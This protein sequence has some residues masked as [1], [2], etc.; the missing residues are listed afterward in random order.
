ME[1]K[2]LGIAI[3]VVAV[4]LCG[5]PGLASLCVGAI[6]AFGGPFLGEPRSDLLFSLS[7]LCAGL[8]FLIIPIV[9]GILTFRKRT[10]TIVAVP[11]GEPI[12]PPS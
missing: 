3:T 11:S 1:N 5:L 7:L 8:I 2:N 10:P 9:A 12:P 6:I 4:L